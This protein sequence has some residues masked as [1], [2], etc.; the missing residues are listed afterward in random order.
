MSV[1][2]N[3]ERAVLV[4]PENLSFFFLEEMF[5]MW[6]VRHGG[7]LRDGFVCSDECK[8][9][10]NVVL[11]LTALIATRIVLWNENVF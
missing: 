11:T 9:F 8:E 1:Y 3:M 4:V 10:K 5:D 6:G 2:D 7:P